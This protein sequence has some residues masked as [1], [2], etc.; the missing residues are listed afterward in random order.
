M[1]CWCQLP[2]ITGHMPSCIFSKHVS[3][4]KKKKVNKWTICLYTNKQGICIY[5]SGEGKAHAMFMYCPK[6][7]IDLLKGHINMFWIT[8]FWFEI[9]N[10]RAKKESVIEH[11]AFFWSLL[12]CFLF[13]LI[14]EV[15]EKEIVIIKFS[16]LQISSSHFYMVQLWSLLLPIHLAISTKSS[17]ENFIVHP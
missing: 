15:R 9:C 14:S 8:G 10:Y 1:A 3:Q 6:K 4:K 13:P 7:H 16:L 17:N 11:Q 12:L 2:I 5:F